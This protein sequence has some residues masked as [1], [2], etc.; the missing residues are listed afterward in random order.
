VGSVPQNQND[1]SS[2]VISFTET[3]Q[4]SR[5]G[6][7]KQWSMCLSSGLPETPSTQNTRLRC[8][9]L[10][11]GVGTVADFGWGV[12]SLLDFFVDIKY[13]KCK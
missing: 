13:V 7:V 12:I 10:A 3:Q 2:P 8:K 9:A 6:F 5:R 1:T 4:P 11:Q